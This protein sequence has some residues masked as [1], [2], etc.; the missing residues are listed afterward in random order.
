MENK[1]LLRKV[2]SAL[3]EYFAGKLPEGTNIFT[4][5]DNAAKEGP[6]VIIVAKGKREDPVG[7]GNYR[8]HVIVTT[9]GLADPDTSTP[10]E[11]KTEFETLAQSVATALDAS[12][13][14]QQI[15]TLEDQFTCWGCS[16][17]TGDTDV[18]VIAWHEMREMELYC[19]GS[20]I[21]T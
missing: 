12:D 3:K 21:D 13:L 17:R 14:T 4:G 5:V 6:C 7:T 19:C 18:E 2:E 10:D 1:T 9:K 8:V 11:A 16:E 15:S 20:D